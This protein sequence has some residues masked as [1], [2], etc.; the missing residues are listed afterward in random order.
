MPG[1]D[2]RRVADLVLAHHPLDLLA[3]EAARDQAVLGRLERLR[4]GFESGG[5]PDQP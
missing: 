3:R 4:A 2:G 5:A 1:G